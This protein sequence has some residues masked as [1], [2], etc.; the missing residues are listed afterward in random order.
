[1]VKK[2]VYGDRM[3]VGMLTT[4]FPDHEYD[5]KGFFVY[6]LAKSLNRLGFDI[7]VVTPINNESKD[8]EVMNSIEIQ[9]FTYMWPKRYHRL[10]GGFGGIPVSIKE[11]K[12]AL[13]QFP[14]FMISFFIKS[15]RTVKKCDVI[16]AH[17]IPSGAIAVF[18]NF[19]YKKKVVLT[20]RNSKLTKTDNRLLRTLI[21]YV[22]RHVDI[23][24][25]ISKSLIG[26]IRDYGINT[27]KIKVIPNGVDTDKFKPRDKGKLR[28]LLELPRDKTI[29]LA[30]C[31]LTKEKGVY[32]L[33][34]AFSQLEKRDKNVLLIIVGAG[35]ERENIR[36]FIIENGMHQSVKLTG[37]VSRKEINHWISSADVLVSASLAETGPNIVLEAMSSGLPVIATDV[38]ICP[39]VIKEGINGYLVPI[40]KPGEIYK[41]ML[42]LRRDG[43]R[44][45]IG[46]NARETI[47]KDFGWEKCAKDYG[48]IFLQLVENP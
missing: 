40:K 34:E 43:L 22:F 24:C 39:D 10:T 1:M 3:R 12:M 35:P 8:V 4:S 27:K 30:V 14:F 44:E 41:K 23:I 17:W 38:G 16:H 47:L 29:M 21:G 11:S 2:Q 26:D 15:L 32:Y 25:V 6:E 28:G 42:R 5:F 36:R 19:F 9:R 37:P 13:M 31:V 46:K 33:L 7:T 20:V 45:E 48:R 18:T